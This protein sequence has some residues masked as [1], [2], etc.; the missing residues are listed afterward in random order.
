MAI[1]KHGSVDFAKGILE[2]ALKADILKQDVTVRELLNIIPSSGEV[3][4]AG[5]VLAWSG[6]ALV[7]PRIADQISE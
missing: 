2:T 1:S 3:N 6:Y 4:V 7:Y 5:G